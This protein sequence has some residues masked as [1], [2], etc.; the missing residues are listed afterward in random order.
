MNHSR[1]ASTSFLHYSI[2]PLLLFLTACAPAVVPLDREEMA[3]LQSERQI[4]V[5]TYTPPRFLYQTPANA[6]GGPGAFNPTTGGFVGGVGDPRRQVYAIDSPLPDPA[7]QVRDLFLQ[8]IEGHLGAARLIESEPLSGDDLKAL[9][10]RFGGGVVLDFKTTTWGLVSGY[11]AF[12]PYQLAYLAIARLSRPETGRVLWQA[13]CQY[14]GVDAGGYL[15]H[16]ET[17]SPVVEEKFAV[18][19]KACAK[20]LLAHFFSTGK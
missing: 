9:A 19:A 18:A 10:K 13:Q 1:S 2:A 3:R 4:R 15:D 6:F 17:S 20:S 16:F 8:G 14:D 7:L 12:R 11:S 5:V